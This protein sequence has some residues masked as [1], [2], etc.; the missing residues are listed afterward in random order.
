MVAGLAVLPGM[1]GHPRLTPRGVDHTWVIAVAD[2]VDA[3][4]EVS[5]SANPL[6]PGGASNRVWYPEDIA[7]RADEVRADPNIWTD[8]SG[9]E[10]PDAPVGIA[11]AGAFCSSITDSR[12]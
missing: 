3:T 10:V 9:D 7:D 2:S 6:D 4:L 1:V 5:L 11:G 8:G 12:L